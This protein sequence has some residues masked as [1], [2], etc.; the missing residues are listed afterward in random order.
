MS[1][2]E[3]KARAL[4]RGPGFWG[5]LLAHH[6][7]GQ[8]DRCYQIWLGKKPVW[9]CARCSGIYPALFVT[10][11]VQFAL[12]VPRS[13]HD[14][15]WLFVLPLPAVV[16]WASSRWGF[17]RGSNRARTLTGVLL[18]IALGRTVY[19]N[20]IEPFNSMVGIQI[21]VLSGII[22]LVEVTARVLRLP[23]GPDRS[24]R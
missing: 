21:G 5:F 19:M 24:E 10:L 4:S 1:D 16:D 9:F 11:I 12:E 13:V 7:P 6:W 17:R 18:G 3:G 15:L 20:M 14:W 2:S 22:L 23:R 8:L